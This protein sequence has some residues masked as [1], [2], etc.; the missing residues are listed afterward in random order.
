MFK[1]LADADTIIAI[2]EGL[3]KDFDQTLQRCFELFGEGA[4]M[5]EMVS[6]FRQEIAHEKI[7]DSEESEEEKEE[8]KMPSQVHRR[9]INLE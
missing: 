8:V 6:K 1:D 5:P 7:S 3:D 9:V 2:Y 4:H